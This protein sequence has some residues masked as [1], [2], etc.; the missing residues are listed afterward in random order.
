MNASPMVR[1]DSAAAILRALSAERDVVIVSGAALHQSAT[2]LMWARLTDA[3]V[4][5]ARSDVTRV[6]NLE[7]AID[8]LVSVEAGV[9]GGVLLVRHG[10][11]SRRRHPVP[12]TP[13]APLRQATRPIDRVVMAPN[14]VAP[15]PSRRPGGTTDRR[16]IGDKGAG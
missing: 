16:A 2:S 3:T 8:S 13:V 5:V 9:I 10:S 4:L 1:E 11:R 12:A 6:E 15:A 7:Y 14:D